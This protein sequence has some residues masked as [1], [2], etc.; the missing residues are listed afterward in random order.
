MPYTLAQLE[1][2]GVHLGVAIPPD[3]ME[4]KRQAAET[5][6]A[7]GAGKPAPKIAYAQARLAWDGARKRAQTDVANLEKAFLEMFKSDPNFADLQKKIR[8]LD[9]ILSKFDESLG[10]TLDKAL[11]AAD[12]D[13]PKFNQ[14]ALAIVKKYQAYVDGDAFVKGIVANPL[15]KMN[16]QADLSS[17]LAQ[18]AQQ[19]AA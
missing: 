2:L 4:K 3:F 9:S 7:R 18:M 19:L 12:A 10:D 1:F 16:F 5:A 14:E 15:V 8:K 13:K 6:T 17:T 11:N